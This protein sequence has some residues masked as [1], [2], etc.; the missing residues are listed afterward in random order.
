M[1][2]VINKPFPA[3]AVITK[4]NKYDM[5]NTVLTVREGATGEVG[6]VELSSAITP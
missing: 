5:M 6:D 4:N 3:K 2:T 1:M